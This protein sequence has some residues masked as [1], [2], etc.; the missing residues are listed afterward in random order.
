MLHFENFHRLF[1][2]RS[3]CTVAHFPWSTTKLFSTIEK[4]QALRRNLQFS[5][6]NKM[7]INSEQIITA[8][9]SH[10]IFLGDE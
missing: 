7:K 10:H 9:V 3:S 1:G 8:D 4:Y 5:K 2:N 6:K